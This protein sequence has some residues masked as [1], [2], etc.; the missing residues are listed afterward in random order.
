MTQQAA[1]VQE[2]N[3]VHYPAPGNVRNLCFAWQDGQR[4]ILNYAYLVSL[5]F[6]P[7]DNCITLTFT[8]HKVVLNGLRLEGLLAGLM[9]QYPRIITCSDERY[10]ALADQDT[11]LVTAITVTD[12]A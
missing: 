10:A 12:A 6:L 5:H 8:T 2:V 1:P 11:F 7:E 4:L 3:A 9:D